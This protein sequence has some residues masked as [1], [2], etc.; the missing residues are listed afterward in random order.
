MPVLDSE[1]KWIGKSKAFIGV[2]IMLITA[3]FGDSGLVNIPVVSELISGIVE[4][5]AFTVG[6]IISIIG[7]AVRTH[8]V[9][10]W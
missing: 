9:K 7:T 5:G 6:G 4:T 8:T 10:L 2:F 1:P 3:L